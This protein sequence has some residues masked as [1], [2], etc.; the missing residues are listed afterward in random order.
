MDWN[1]TIGSLS[2]GVLDIAVVVIVLIGAISGCIT[3]F[4]RSAT[5]LIGFVLAIP[6]SLLFTKTVAGAIADASGFSYFICSLIAFVAVA[7]AVY[8]VLCIFGSQLANV[9]GAS[10]ALHALDSALG[11]I[12]GLVGS[13][14]S[15]SLIIMIM[16]FQPFIDISGLTA[17]SLVVRD[18]I[19]PL[20]PSVLG[21]ISGVSNG[22]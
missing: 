15:L 3:G 5:R 19:E 10:G 20:F 1:F 2:F 12:W 4:S 14:V 9:L 17:N 8:I 7:L 22:V 18:I 6:I 21:I 16:N 13:A 11:F